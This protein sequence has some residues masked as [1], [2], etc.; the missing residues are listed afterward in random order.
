MLFFWFKQTFASFFAIIYP[1]VVFFGIIS[2]KTQSCLVIKVSDDGPGIS[3]EETEKI[4][5]RFYSNRARS[6]A[7][8]QNSITHTGL[9]LSIVKA[10]CDELEGQ[11][12]V[13]RDSELGGALFEIKLPL[14]S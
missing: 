6:L 13:G 14:E 12:K 2:G 11:I 10:I 8:L 7:A 3:E 5:N 9:G 4:F 1:N